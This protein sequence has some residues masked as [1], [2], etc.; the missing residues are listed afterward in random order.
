MTF[1]AERGLM[2]QG[3]MTWTTEQ[4]QDRA[5]LRNTDKTTTNETLSPVAV[6]AVN[7]FSGEIQRARFIFSWF[8]SSPGCLS[9]VVLLLTVPL[10]SYGQ[11]EHS[12]PG[13]R[14]RQG[15]KPEYRRDAGVGECISSRP[16]R[17]SE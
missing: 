17:Q 9:R 10:L 16:P 2:K 1:L 3:E 15:R 12:V 4:L 14:R 8:H 13:F 6:F 11:I 5:E 7:A